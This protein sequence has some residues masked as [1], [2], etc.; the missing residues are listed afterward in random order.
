MADVLF[1]FAYGLSILA[2]ACFTLAGVL[3]TLAEGLSTL[4]DALF[5]FTYA[6]FDCANGL[7]TLNF[8][9]FILLFDYSLNLHL[10]FYIHYPL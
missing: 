4:A 7:F 1:T 2:D 6:L 8:T 9:S 3:F 10:I 5:C